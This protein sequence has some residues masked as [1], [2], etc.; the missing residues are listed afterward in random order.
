MAREVDPF[1]EAEAPHIPGDFY[2]TSAGAPKVTDPTGALVK[3]GKNK[4]NVKTLT[5]GRPSGMG[6]GIEDTTVLSQWG[7]RMVIC[8]IGAS[9]ELMMEATKVADLRAGDPDGKAWKDAGNAL[10]LKSKDLAKAGLAAEMG[11]HIHGVTENDS[12]DVSWLTLA[13]AGEVLGIPRDIQAAC[14]QAYR[15]MLEREGLEELAVEARVVHDRYRKAGSLDRI[16]RCNKLLRF[17]SGKLIPKGTVVVSDL[18]TGVEKI[19]DGY[20]QAYGVQEVVYAE[21]VPYDPET[22]ERGVWPWKVS[23]QH[24]LIAHIDV[25]AILAGEPAVCNL[26]YVDLIEARVAADLCH[27]ADEWAR[28][29]NVFAHRAL[30]ATGGWLQEAQ[31]ERMAQNAAHDLGGTPVLPQGEPAEQATVEAVEAPPASLPPVAV[32]EGCDMPDATHASTWK[33]LMVAFAAMGKGSHAMKWMVDLAERG[34]FHARKRTARCFELYRGLLALVGADLGNDKVVLELIGLTLPEED[35]RKANIAEI[36]ATFSVTEAQRFAELAL[37]YR[38]GT[39][40]LTFAPDGAR[41][42][43]P[44]AA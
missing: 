7:E 10:S 15:D 27:A 25:K 3:S 30:D 13:E 33:P 44:P 6:K 20:W 32:D 34:N 38:D 2:R 17:A 39:L 35:V 11:T 31:Q 18:K 22:G 40:S 16:V 23:Q 8:G 36:L 24:G 5:Y 29:R 37:A 28:N 12:L 42:V 14:L 26:I 1:A 41:T 21:G 9:E 19:K 43:H 4:G